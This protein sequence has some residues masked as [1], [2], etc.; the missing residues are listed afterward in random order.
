M[1]NQPYLRQDIS[2]SPDT[3]GNS[4]KCRIIYSATGQVIDVLKWEYNYPEWTKQLY[5][6]P[7]LHV[8]PIQ[9]RAVLN[10][11]TAKIRQ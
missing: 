3:N 7:H 9:Y 8:R 1:D 10:L 4:R 11:E 2:T 6:L 5:S